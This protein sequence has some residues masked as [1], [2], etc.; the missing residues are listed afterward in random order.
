VLLLKI[1]DVSH[2]A[3]LLFSASLHE[4]VNFYLLAGFLTCLRFGQ[5]SRPVGQWQECCRNVFCETHSSG[6]VQD[7]HL[8]PFYR[9]TRKDNTAPINMGAKIQ[10]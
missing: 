5:P 3:S 9:A 10:N 8:I 7:L 2:G 1:K 4:S 6:S